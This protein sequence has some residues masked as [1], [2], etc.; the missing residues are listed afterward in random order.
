MQVQFCVK[1]I[2]NTSGLH[3]V[4]TVNLGFG[5]NTPLALINLSTCTMSSNESYVEE[6]IRRNP[7]GIQPVSLFAE[8]YKGLAPLHYNVPPFR[9]EM[10]DIHTD[11]IPPPTWHGYTG[12]KTHFTQQPMPSTSQ[13]QLSGGYAPSRNQVDNVKN[14]SPYPAQPLPPSVP[15]NSASLASMAETDAILSFLPPRSHPMQVDI[16]DS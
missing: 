11:L 5:F 1:K 7:N 16:T 2:D 14:G 13:F 3:A 9:L 6:W 10:Q 12:A 8:D 15:C 4:T